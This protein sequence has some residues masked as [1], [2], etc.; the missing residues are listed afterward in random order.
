[1]NYKEEIVFRFHYPRGLLSKRMSSLEIAS[2]VMPH[3]PHIVP[4]MVNMPVVQRSFAKLTLRM[5]TSPKEV[6][7]EI[8]PWCTVIWR[9][10]DDDIVEMRPVMPDEVMTLV[11]MA[12]ARKPIYASVFPV[13]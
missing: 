1:M 6:L 9:E 10:E 3:M 5:A 11:E 4:L 12:E 13:F 2:F 8:H 7:D